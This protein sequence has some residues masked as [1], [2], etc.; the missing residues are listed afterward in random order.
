MP[1][2]I[3]L[4]L[5]NRPEHS[6]STINA[7]LE[8]NGIADTD[9]YVFC[10]GPKN[11]S[12][13]QGVDGVRRLVENLTG[14]KSITVTRHE[15][16]RGL[17]ASIISGVTE[18][19]DKH[20]TVIVLEDDLVTH[21]DTVNYFNTCLSQYAGYSGV[22]SISGYNHPPSRMSIPDD[23]EY[24]V[25][26][27]P[28]MQCWGWAT[29]RDRWAKADWSMT[30]F[31]VFSSSPALVEAYS[32]WI[33]KDSLGTLRAYMEGLKDVWA[34][35]WVYAHFKHHAVCI[36]P[37]I[38]YVDNIGLDGSGANCGAQNGL[39]ND[40]STPRRECNS[41]RLPHMVFVAPDIFENFMSV[42]DPKRNTHKPATIDTS[43]VN[44]KMNSR[45][46]YW[47]ARPHLLVRKILSKLYHYVK[48]AT[49]SKT[50]QPVAKDQGAAVLKSKIPLA[51]LGTEYGGWHMPV[52]G[53]GP[54]DVMVSA[55]AGEDISFDI[56]VAKKYQA[57]IVIIDPTP[58][59]LLHF[60]ETK[61]LILASEKAPIN[62]NPDEVYVADP[63]VFDHIS[64]TPVGLWDKNTTI[65]FFP[66]A[67][68][69]HVSHSI[70]NMHETEGGFDAEC[71]TLSTLMERESLQSISILKMDIEGAEYAVIDD[72]IQHSIKPKYLM[73][74]FHPGQDEQ[75]KVHKTRTNGYVMKLSE[76][77]Y[78]LVQNSGW[79]YVFEKR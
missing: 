10:D 58:R 75:E 49:Q 70:D 51:K 31:S 23:Y 18:V 77:G 19:L 55:G 53:I 52:E 42:F 41:L 71:V 66:P 28:R 37:T 14:F 29:W 48:P 8:N 40:L 27:I 65:R 64:F 73:I 32:Y 1:A 4:F 54:E 24:D 26:G 60:E 17:A 34:S 12:D 15:T 5:Y 13:V 69:A 62:N 47:F 25:Y 39:Q 21:P 57:R 74:E 7:L 22:F 45:L 30:D 44:N 68:D 35:R 11:E 2:P 72:M 59:A 46:L 16:N 79:D 67:N 6:K 3:A 56:E 76:Y 38:S 33:G 50:E 78:N 63:D 9:L 20:G 43:K 36:C 61:G